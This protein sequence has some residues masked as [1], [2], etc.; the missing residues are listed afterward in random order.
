MGKRKEEDKGLTADQIMSVLEKEY[1]RHGRFIPGQRPP[2]P[3]LKDAFD[4][5]S[6]KVRLAAVVELGR[7]RDRKSLPLLKSALWDWYVPI[8]AVATKTLEAMGDTSG[9]ELL[10]SL[11]NTGDFKLRFD[12]LRVLAQLNDESLRPVFARAMQSEDPR[13]STLASQ[14]MFSLGERA[15]LESLVSKLKSGTDA[16]RMEAAGFLATIED[17]EAQTAVR[18][19]LNSSDVAPSL[20]KAVSSNLRRARRGNN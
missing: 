19:F 9:K 17:P 2:Y 5:N 12:A 20:R 11:A 18:K 4:L 7:R 13:I 10:I 8:R 1:S 15:G 6:S 14:A 16:E 3:P